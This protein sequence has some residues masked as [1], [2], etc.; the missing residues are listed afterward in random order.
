VA[1]HGR[2]VQEERL[3]DLGVREP[4]R[5]QPDDVAL[6]IGEVGGR[7]ARAL[8]RGAAATVGGLSLIAG[9]VL[10][11]VGLIRAR[12]VPAWAAVLLPVAIV[13]NIVGFSAG[14]RTV[15]LASCVLALAG[16][17]RAAVEVLAPSRPE[18]QGAAVPATR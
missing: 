17:G 6:A 18:R 16:L 15:L 2:L 9:S 10:L 13:A 3:G 8:G 5:Q 14:S 4:A 1:L 11:A 7:L 12:A